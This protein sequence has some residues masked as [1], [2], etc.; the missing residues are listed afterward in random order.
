MYVSGLSMLAYPCSVRGWRF[1][2]VRTKLQ[3]LDGVLLPDD[4]DFVDD[5]AR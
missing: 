2:T 1:H 5:V 4:V 3:G